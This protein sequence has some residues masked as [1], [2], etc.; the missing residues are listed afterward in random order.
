MRADRGPAGYLTV[1]VVAEL[2][3]FY[4]LSL[5]SQVLEP[6]QVIVR[7]EAVIG[8]DSVRPLQRR[9]PRDRIISVSE[10]I[11]TLADGLESSSS[12]ILC[13]FSIV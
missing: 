10:C 6:G 1:G 13:S 8:G 3:V 5:L 2:K 7:I 9:Y 11:R 12:V 4:R